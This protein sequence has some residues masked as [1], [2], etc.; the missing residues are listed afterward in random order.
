MSDFLNF[1]ADSEEIQELDS[2]LTMTVLGRSGVGKTTLA[3]SAPNTI[4]L[5]LENKTLNFKN[6]EIKDFIYPDTK[7]L[8]I[9]NFMEIKLAFQFL[10]LHCIYRDQLRDAI[11]DGKPQKEIERLKDKLYAIAHNKAKRPEGVQPKIYYNVVFDSLTEAQ[12]INLDDLG[13]IKGKGTSEVVV[14]LEKDEVLISFDVKGKSINDYGT[15]TSHLRKVLR[16]FKDLKMNKIYNVL[17]IR[18]RDEDTNEI[19]IVPDLSPKLA[20]N[21]FAYSDITG[22][23]EGK[24]IKDE[25]TKEKVYWRG[26][27]F[28]PQS[29]YNV[30]V[31]D[32]SGRLGGAIQYPRLEDII[33][34]T[35]SAK[36]DFEL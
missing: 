35:G 14:N 5:E 7:I 33:E 11:K 19:E 1:I 24:M 25:A 23:Y 18:K 32:G 12:K 4:I 29:G 3:A 22:Y 31:K 21:L 2:Y 28:K 20:T 10:V 26:I 15:N 6:P 13:T 27:M 30:E 9:K 36:K 17:A 8:K 34:K 16:Y